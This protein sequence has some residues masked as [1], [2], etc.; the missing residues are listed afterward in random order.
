MK[1]PFILLMLL[2]TACT[3]PALRIY[4]NGPAIFV[5]GDPWAV[6]AYCTRELATVDNRGAAAGAAVGCAAWWPAE[7]PTRVMIACAEGDEPCVAHELRHV[8]QPEW[9]HE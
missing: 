1:P 9:R 2:L 4:T 5:T 6:R 3:T 7:R 8:I